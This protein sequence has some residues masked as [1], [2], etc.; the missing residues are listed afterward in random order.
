MPEIEAPASQEAL[1]VVGQSPTHHDFVDKVEGSL[2]YA[3]DWQL[4]GLL[5]GKVVRCLL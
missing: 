4:P 5:H 1:R 2:L 3:A